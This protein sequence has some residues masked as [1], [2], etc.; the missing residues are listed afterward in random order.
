MLAA[1]IGKYLLE[2]KMLLSVAESCSGGLISHLMT[3]V[4]GSSEY[5]LGG[6]IAYSNTLKEKI[7]GVS[8]DTIQ[9]FGA[10]SQQTALEMAGGVRHVLSLSIP[11]ARLIGLAVTGIAG[12]G[13]AMPD[14]PVGLTW[15]GLST[16]MGTWA[17]RY[18]WTGDR[19][20]NKRSSAQQALR[21]LLQY[22]QCGCSPKG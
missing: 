11:E 6:V 3:N 9:N 13:G 1:R 16:P 2:K 14:K 21:L 20:Q 4:S 8:P 12:P 15:I 18:I 7:L 10:V 17:Y 19:I 5:F 22:L